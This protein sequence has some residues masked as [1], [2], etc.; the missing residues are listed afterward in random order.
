V[1]L[2]RLI[3]QTLANKTT[4]IR[5]DDEQ[6]GL[7]KVQQYQLDL[8]HH[9]VS[10]MMVDNFIVRPKRRYVD[11]FFKRSY[12]ETLDDSKQTVLETH[13]SS[14]PSEANALTAQ[15]KNNE[16]SHR[17]D[18]LILTMQLSL[19]TDESIADSAKH[20]L[21]YLGQHLED[22]QNVPDV[23]AQL[24]LIQ[25]LQTELFW[26]AIDVPE[27]ERVRGA[28]RNLIRVLDK[29]EKAVVYSNFSDGLKSKQHIM[30]QHV[31]ILNTTIKK[32]NTLLSNIKI[33]LQF[34]NLSAINQCD[35]DTLERLLLEAS[36]VTDRSLYH[37]KVLKN[38]PLGSF[39]RELVGLDRQAAK[40]IFSDFLDEG[41]YTVEQIQF[42]NQIVDYLTTNGVLDV[43]HIF[44]SPFTD[45]HNESAYGFFEEHKVT[46]LFGRIRKIKVNSEVKQERMS[47]R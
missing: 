4:Q 21:I 15:E 30:A 46:E 24:A 19:L 39:I 11:A 5:S 25:E 1:A 40:A 36:G 35:L 37:E 6:Q 22:K 9:Q 17:F 18:H 2:S 31:L 13:L 27:L 20:R 3:D 7:K 47:Q 26:Q 41:Q 38:K 23:A 8:L 16:L 44:E 34:R 33:S 42:V 14:L 29:V 45:L 12:W 28:L 43:K 10:G 32:P